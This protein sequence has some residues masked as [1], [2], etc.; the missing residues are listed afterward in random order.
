MRT[1]ALAALVAVAAFSAGCAT[2]PPRSLSAQ[3]CGRL[4][5]YHGPKAVSHLGG[6]VLSGG[7]PV[8]DAIVTARV[9]P[10]G[11]TV[12][13]LTAPNG[14]FS[15]SETEPGFTLVRVC[16][17]GWSSMEFQVSVSAQAEDVPI[18]VELAPESR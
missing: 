12:D 18:M 11:E 15:I 7:T 4:V 8:P 5:E 3:G 1:S 2:T 10:E 16:K 9:L 14:Y 13:V 17:T 6:L